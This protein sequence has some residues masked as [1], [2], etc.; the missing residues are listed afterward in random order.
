MFK[1]KHKSRINLFD[2]YN[3]MI[4]SPQVNLGIKRLCLEVKLKNIFIFGYKN[5]LVKFIINTK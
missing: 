1:S 4:N 3:I 2:R 5:Y